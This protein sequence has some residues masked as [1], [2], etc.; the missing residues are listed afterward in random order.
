MLLSNTESIPGNLQL[1]P[2]IWPVAVWKAWHRNSNRSPAIRNQSEEITE[3]CPCTPAKDTYDPAALSLCHKIWV[4][5]TSSFSRHTLTGS[6][7]QVSHSTRSG[8]SC[9][10]NGDGVRIQNQKLKTNRDHQISAT[11]EDKQRRN[12]DNSTQSPCSWLGSR[13]SLSAHTG[14]VEINCQ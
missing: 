10:W 13:E 6:P 9:F 2:K 3:Q 11:W 4:G 14:T 5:V 8:F 1:F 12:A 7:S